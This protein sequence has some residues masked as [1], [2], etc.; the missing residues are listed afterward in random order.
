MRIDDICGGVWERGSG[1]VDPTNSLPNA[2]LY[3]W[4]DAFFEPQTPRFRCKCRNAGKPYK[5]SWLGC[6]WLAVVAMVVGLGGTAGAQPCSASKWGS[7]G[8]SAAKQADPEKEPV[9]PFR[10]AVDLEHQSAR[11]RGAVMGPDICA[12]RQHGEAD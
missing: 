11:C 12:G 9:S 3:R 2:I 8:V 6:G 10:L 7:G 1:R 4:R 5:V